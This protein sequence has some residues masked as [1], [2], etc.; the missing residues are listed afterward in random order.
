M[1][2]RAPRHV[3]L[4]LD[5]KQMSLNVVANV[6]KEDD[7]AL[8]M[9]HASVVTSVIPTVVQRY[10]DNNIDAILQPSGSRSIAVVSKGE[11]YRESVRMHFIWKKVPAP[12]EYFY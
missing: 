2:I 5:V 4:G 6:P 10:K 3:T 11:K 8:A 1:R 9:V 7:P 12:S